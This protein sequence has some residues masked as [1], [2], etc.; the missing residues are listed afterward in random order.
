MHVAV[1]AAA[2][3]SAALLVDACALWSLMPAWWGPMALGCV[4]LPAAALACA[5]ASLRGAAAV[6]PGDSAGAPGLEA[7]VPAPLRPYA[8]VVVARPLA[9]LAVVGVPVC[10]AALAVT[11]HAERSLLEGVERMLAEGLVLTASFVA[12]GRR[13]GLRR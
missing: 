2:V 3:T 5:G 8:A 11:A 4:L 6:T 13:L 1:A 7:D 10:L 9:L 12:L